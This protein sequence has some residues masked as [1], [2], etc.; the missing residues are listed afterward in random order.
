[1]IRADGTKL[2]LIARGEA[3]RDTTGRIV[4]LRGTVQDIT[5]RKQ[6]EEARFRHAVIVESS[7][8]AIIPK[9]LEGVILT[10]NRGAQCLFGFTE[11]EAVGQPITIIV[12]E[13]LYNEEKEILRRVRSGEHIEHFETVRLAPEQF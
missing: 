3:Q 8:D 11:A 12:P 13:E 1:M 4:Q 7:D 10:W 6:A 5:E 9:D 2:W